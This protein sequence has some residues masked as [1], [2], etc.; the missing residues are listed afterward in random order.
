MRIALGLEYNGTFFSG[1][2]SQSNSQ[3]VQDALELALK[4]ITGQ[5]LRV[6]AAGRTDTGVHALLQV[7]HFETDVYRPI[8]AWVRGVNAFLPSAVRV[9]WAQEVDSGF[10]A[11]FSAVSR[12]Y[13]YLLVNQSY[14]PAIQYDRMGWYH[15]P[16]DVDAMRLA[17]NFLKGQHDFS[18]FRASECQAKSPIKTM[19]EASLEQYGQHIRFCFT[20]NAFLHHQVRNMVGALVYIGNGKFKPQQMQIWL[21]EKNRKNTPPTF[22]PNGLYLSGVGYLSKW[23]LPETSKSLIF[24]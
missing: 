24:M 1:W 23:G 11:R 9:C 12:S 19:H 7:V 5:F 3:G 18:A 16:L 22:S 15:L 4:Q 2:Q 21:A 10:H 14:A 8:T 20:A 6:H 17:M 13:Q